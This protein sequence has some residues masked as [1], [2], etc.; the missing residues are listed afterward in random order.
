ML[1]LRALHSFTETQN[2]EFL[3]LPAAELIEYIGLILASQFHSWKSAIGR[4]FSNESSFDGAGCGLGCDSTAGFFALE[5][6]SFL[7]RGS[8]TLL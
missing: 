3:T 7:L 4:G 1:E 5:T 8:G 2:P 6:A